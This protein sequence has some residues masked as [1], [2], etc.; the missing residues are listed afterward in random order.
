VAWGRWSLAAAAVVA[1]LAIGSFLWSSLPSAGPARLSTGGPASASREA[2]EA[3]ELAMQFQGVQNDIRRAQQT[4]ERALQIDP[5]FA[6]ALRYHASNYAILLLNGYS[7][8]TS[9]LYRAEEELRETARLAPDLLSLPAALATVHLAQGRKELIPWGQLDRALEQ[10]PSNVNNRLW[11]G[12]ALWLSG[13]ARAAQEEFR[14][15][16][17]LRPLFGPGRMFFAVTLREGSNLEGAIRETE[18]VLEQAPNNI[19]AVSNLTS[20][21]LDRGDPVSARTL[22]EARRDLYAENYLWRQS[23]ALVLAVE[24]RREEAIAAMDDETLKFAAAAFP[25][26]LAVAEFYAVLGNGSRALE[27]IERAVRNGDE[28]TA[29]FR[30][31]PRLASIREDPRFEQILASVE[32]RRTL[33]SR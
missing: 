22:L 1:A 24:G 12:I 3:F 5:G 20:F 27:W 28:R 6:E 7:N 13:D 30:A 16:L 29:W 33:Q 8:D 32:S 4:L 14:R 31:N 26:T 18:K 25:S 11:R 23:W 15:A 17:D 9:L 19:S 21:Y 10:D 2:N